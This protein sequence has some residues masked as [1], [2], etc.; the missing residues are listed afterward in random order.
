MTTA[1]HPRLHI[2][3]G[4]EIP[5]TLLIF[6]MDKYCETFSPRSWT[7]IA[8][9]GVNYSSAGCATVY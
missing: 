7:N 6:S 5:E 1:R 8:E 9:E 4:V 2:I 3:Y